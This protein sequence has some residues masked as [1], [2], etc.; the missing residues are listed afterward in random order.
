MKKVL[1][2]IITLTLVLSLSSCIDDF[3]KNDNKQVPIY[4]GMTI[5]SS[6][7]AADGILGA[8]AISTPSEDASKGT[9]KDIQI[10]SEDYYAD[11]GE[12]ILI[13]I[14]LSNPDSFEI[15]SFTLNGEKYSSYMFEYGSNMETIIIKC[16]VGRQSGEH[17]Y[18]IDAIKYVDKSAVKDVAIRG[19]QT[20]KVVVSEYEH[21]ANCK[22]DNIDKITTLEAKEPN[23]KEDG[24]TEGKKCELCNT[25][26]LPQETLAKLD[27]IPGEWIIDKEATVAED[28]LMHTECVMCSKKLKEKVIYA[29]GSEG[30][31]YVVNEDNETCTVTGI[32]SCTDMDIV[33]PAYI[34]GFKV[35][36]IGDGAFILESFKSVVMSDTIVTIGNDAFGECM[37][38]ESI[39][40]SESLTTIGSYAFQCCESLKSL[41]IPA[42]LTDLGMGSLGYC[43]S[44]K[45][46]DVDENNQ[47]YTSIDGSLYTKDGKTL[48]QYAIGNGETVV[49]IPDGVTCVGYTSFCGSTF[50]TDVIIPDSVILIERAAF[51]RCTALRNVTIGSR[52]RQIDNAECVISD[53][54]FCDCDA[55]TTLI[56]GNTVKALERDNVGPFSSCSALANL[57][58]GDNLQNI[59]ASDFYGC[60]SLKN[61]S[62][63]ERN[64][65]FKV[66]DGSLYSKDGCT[67]V[68]YVGDDTATSFIV[69]T[70]VTEIGANAFSYAKNLESIIL[71]DGLL[72][73]GSSAFIGCSGLKS[74]IIPNGVTEIPSGAFS[75]CTSLEMIVMHDNI[76]VIGGSAFIGCTALT[77]IIIPKTVETIGALAFNGCGSTLTIYCRSFSKPAGF[78]QYWSTSGARVVWG[79][80]G[81]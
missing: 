78:H 19:N 37:Y 58:I 33:I 40:L 77:K 2:L 38:M 11:L 1:L 45:N 48:V 49:R 9:F 16:N 23:C 62:V 13:S 24:L 67:L 68:M 55:L 32:G 14:H 56:L 76:T 20:I 51:H 6:Y 34:D 73:I 65:Y 79:Y 75:V 7:Q 18:T 69:P 35:T 64:Q 8:R 47:Y 53:D 74:I 72:S 12:E 36:A 22:H 43:I 28:G 21:E 30:L 50:I 42:S 70:D 3:M 27:C 41:Y 5:A 31:A 29:T 4:E 59:S 80:T 60:R 54:A 25:V 57:V 81:N 39:I 17:H 66:V 44:L 61:I 15:L 10:E 63:S 52:D 46:I 71:P 26:I